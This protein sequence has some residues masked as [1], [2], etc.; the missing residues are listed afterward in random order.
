MKPKK[1]DNKN[2]LDDIYEFLD[3]KPKMTKKQKEDMLSSTIGEDLSNPNF[4]L[5]RWATHDVKR[6]PPVEKIKEV[7][8]DDPPLD[9]SQPIGKPTKSSINDDLKDDIIKGGE[10]KTDLA[11]TC[12]LLLNE[13]WRKRK[14]N[15]RDRS[16]PALTTLETIAVLYDVEWL[17]SWIDSYTEY[18][19]SESGKGRQDIVDIA[20][21]SIDKETSIRKE[22]YE[23]MGKR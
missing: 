18:V 23:F 22:M 10:T 14:T 17:R 16:I 7:V 21:Y 19:T 8:V 4:D 9:V 5:Q 15:L 11:N 13:K 2:K 3:E 1:N 6:N 12:E 20:K